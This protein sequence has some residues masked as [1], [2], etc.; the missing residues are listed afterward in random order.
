MLG[1]VM[2]MPNRPREPHALQPRRLPSGRWK[3]RVQAWDPVTG[4]RREVTRTFDTFRDAQAWSRA[5][6][7]RL[8]QGGQPASADSFGAFLDCWLAHVAQSGRAPT[9]VADYRI[10]ARK[11]AAALGAKPLRDLTPLDFQ[12]LYQHLAGQGLSPRSVQYV[13]AV[14]RRALAD[15]VAWGLLPANPAAGARPPRP[16]A[17][18]AEALTPEQARAF[19]AVADAD[20]W[21]ALWYLLALAG[22]RRGEA[23]ALR[24]EDLDRAHRRILVRRA[25]VQSGGRAVLR[26]RTKTPHGQ[27]AVDCPP[28]LWEILESHRAAQA[29]QA[30]ATGR[31]MP[32]WVFTTRTGQP[33]HPS[34]AYH[35]FKRLAA[36]AGVPDAHP[37]TLR[38]TMATLWLREGVPPH[39]VAQRLGH[40]DVRIT[41]Q[42]YAHVLP[43]QQADAAALDRVWRG[44]GD[45]PATGR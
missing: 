37:H 23:L 45:P 19:L 28:F 41:L 24:W 22:L 8:R 43:G 25:W 12:A 38:H 18:T 14:C 7:Q 29:A 33:I 27:R 10:Q 31:P 26:D 15:A 11:A 39:V 36:Q 2:R 20:R 9:T 42:L 35:R 5:E 16:A 34:Q 21:R 40:A 4:R 13:H 6:E 30:A 1:P 17:R 44:S 32:A 3:G